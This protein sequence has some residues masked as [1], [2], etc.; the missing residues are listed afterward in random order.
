M[1]V[2]MD[3]RVTGWTVAE[4][5]RKPAAAFTLV[6]LLVVI[7]IIGI[8]IGML[9]P[10]VQ[11]VR[12]STRRI[13][14]LNHL[15]QLGIGCLNYEGR[16]MR[17]PQGAVMGQGTGWAGFILAD[18]EQ[19]ALAAMVS[20]ADQ[21]WNHPTGDG[22]G[23]ASHW[24]SASPGNH[25]AIQTWIPVFR[26]PSDQAPQH[27]PS[28][29][30]PQVPRR[31]P[32]SY[33]GCATGTEDNARRLAA[34]GTVTPSQ[35]REARN[36]M[37]PPTQNAPYYAHQRTPTTVGFSDVT[38]GTSTTILMGETVFDTSPFT[39]KPGSP[40]SWST[41]NRGIDHWYIGSFEI[42]QKQG[43]DLSEFIGSTKNPLNLYHQY[44]E[45]RLQNMGS[46]PTALFDQMAFG[47][48][49]WHSGSGVNFVFADGSASYL[50]S[51]IDAVILSNLGNRN[52]GQV[53]RLAE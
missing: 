50:G 27:M 16:N 47:F 13:S 14:C 42:D 52:D 5:G 19:A 3:D 29:S 39:A 37:L 12:E 7:A 8:L 33:I 38:D 9:L 36:G 46:N 34:W 53:T 10:A 28:G 43:T 49:S 51:A 22:P 20:F 1:S 23:T 44:S 4:A 26:C 21:Q 24:T 45:E 25:E 48:A 41:S 32:S 15:R 2:P 35:A 11:Q 17:F 6:E 31:V 40:V 18:L 30:G